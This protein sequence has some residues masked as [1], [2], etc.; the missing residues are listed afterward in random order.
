MHGALSVVLVIAMT[1]M[2]MMLDRL[3]GAT[4]RLSISRIRSFRHSTEYIYVTHSIYNNMEPSTTWLSFGCP[5]RY[6]GARFCV[7]TL[8]KSIKGELAQPTVSCD[9]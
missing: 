8:V 7:S 2:V 4:K 9:R 3:K 5:A 1:E 6:T